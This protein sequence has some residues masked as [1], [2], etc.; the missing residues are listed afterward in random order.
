[1]VWAWAWSRLRAR[2]HKAHLTPKSEKTKT[3]LKYNRAMRFILLASFLFLTA[4]AAYSESSG[5]FLYRMGFYD[6]A[7]ADWREAAKQGD[8]G[9]AFRLGAAY[10]DGVIV[11]RDPKE[12]IQWIKLGVKL[13]ESRAELELGTIYDCDL[14]KCSEFGIKRSTR[15]AAKHYLSAA[16]KGEAV[17][18]YNVAVML[19]EGKGIGQDVVEAYKFYTLAIQND[20]AT[21]AKPARDKLSYKMSRAQIELAL[22]R[23]ETVGNEK[24]TGLGGL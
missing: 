8:G 4:C 15:L 19:E 12:A 16:R 14:H 18:Q 1:M 6:E 23:A 13:G 3:K 2:P 7:L 24:H 9:A 21:F 22:L 10:L 5:N 20:F 17:A 11:K